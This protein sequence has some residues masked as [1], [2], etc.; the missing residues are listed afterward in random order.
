LSSITFTWEPDPAVFA[1]SINAVALALENRAPLLVAASEEMQA[2]IRERFETATDPEGNPWKEWSESYR[3]YAEAHNVGILRQSDAL[4][5]AAS[6]SEATVITHDTVFY[7]TSVLPSYGLEHE[8]GSDKLPQRA[9][10]GMSDESALKVFGLFG[11]WFEEAISLYPTS[12]GKVG[13]RHSIR[14][15]TGFVSRSSVGKSPLPKF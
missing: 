10:L 5:E 4:M 3:P 1:K 7:Q 8:R 2:T 13:A 11:E 15:A 14:G 12:T 9:F 6:S